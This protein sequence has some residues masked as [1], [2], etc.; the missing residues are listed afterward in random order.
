VPWSSMIPQKKLQGVLV[1]VDCLHRGARLEVKNR[2]GQVTQLF[3]ADTS[4]LK[5]ACGVQK[6]PRPVSISYA[7]QPDEDRH[8]AGDVLEFAWR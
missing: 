1:K 3:R 5:L 4:T 6:A 7:A 2:A 8:T